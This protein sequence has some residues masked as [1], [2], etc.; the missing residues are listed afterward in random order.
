MTNALQPT[1]PRPVIALFC[2][3][4]MEAFLSNAIAGILQA[5]ID[6]GQICVGCPENALKSVKSVARLHSTQIRVIPTQKLYPNEVETEKY[7]SF[8]SR[9]FTDISWKKIFFIRQLIEIHPHVVFADLDISWIRNPMPYLARVAEVYPIAFQT[10][11]L[12]RFPPALCCGFAS[13][14]KSERAIALLDASIELH[15]GQIGNDDLLDDQVAF[16]HLIENDVTWL[17]YIYWLP[18]ALFLNGLGYR[19]LQQSGENPCPMEGELLPFLFHANWTVGADNKRKLLTSTGTWL[20]ADSSTETALEDQGT[21]APPPALTVICPVY[22]VRGDIVE[23]VRV[24]TEGQ[25]C[26]PHSYRVFVVAGSAT[27][28][29][30]AALRKVLRNQDALLRVPG[31]G[32]DADLWNAGAREAKTPWLLF[33]E[34]H[35]LPERDSLSALAAWIAANPNGEACNFKIRS[36]GGHHIAGLMQRWFTEVHTAWASA[37]TW[38]RLHRTAFAIRRDIFEDMGPFESEYGQF[39]PPL[40]SARMHQRSLTISALPTSGIL[41]DDSPQ[42]SD[43]HNDTADYVRGEMAAR[44]VSD[45]GFFERYFGPAPS[46]GP[47][48]ILSAR[49]ARSIVKGLLATALHRPGKAFYPLKQACSLLPTALGSLRVRARLLTALTRADEYV[50]M[51]LPVAEQV[52]W[53]RFLLAHRR[54]I[55]TEQ[56][57]WMLRNPLPSLPI[58]PEHTTWPITAIGRYAIIGLHTLEQLDGDVFRWTHPVFL[59]KLAISAEGVLTLETRNARSGIGLSDIVVVIGWRILSPNDL[60]LDDAGNIKLKI[61]AQST[62]VGETDIVVIVRELCEPRAKSGHGRRLGLPLFSVNFKCDN[63]KK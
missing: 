2:T 15:A 43:H 49:H 45:P 21:A 18:E 17:R 4:G 52:R 27:E 12:P 51:H 63:L 38:R 39:T 24:W 54:L 41:H 46:Q 26:D 48:M 36:L 29:D 8:G 1:D 30:E 25:D 16:Q 56:M 23:R 59:L 58:G 31:A 28:L 37:S 35:G 44:T 3:R 11:G 50:L 42:I 5:G 33:V 60:A 14:A 13:F 57:L 22:D 55:R 10:E 47:D 6:A 61:Q 34:A 20:L 32:R 53:K 9:S 40:F 19:N 62:P 7:S